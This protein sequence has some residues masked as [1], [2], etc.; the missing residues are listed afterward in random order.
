MSQTTPNSKR[1]RRGVEDDN[2][3]IE[4]A[5]DHS[6]QHSGYLVDREVL[7]NPKLPIEKR[8]KINKARNF[9]GEPEHP[10]YMSE[11][12]EVE[13][14]KYIDQMSD[15]SGFSTGPDYE[16][17]LENAGQQQQGLFMDNSGAEN[18]E[19]S[20]GLTQG[21]DFYSSFKSTPTSGGDIVQDAG[22][23]ASLDYSGGSGGFHAHSMK[24]S[25]NEE[26]L[27][28]SQSDQG[29]YGSGGTG[30]RYSRF[31]Q[32]NSNGPSSH[33]SFGGQSFDQKNSQSSQDSSNEA[34]QNGPPAMQHFMPGEDMNWQS[35]RQGGS[36]RNG[37]PTEYSYSETDGNA[38]IHNRPSPKLTFGGQSF[39]EKPSHTSSQANIHTAQGGS[40]TVNQQTQD[41]PTLQMSTLQSQAMQAKENKKTP[42]YPTGQSTGSIPNNINLNI[43]DTPQSPK[44][45]M[46]PA[47]NPSVK[48][49]S[50]P[51][52]SQIPV[53]MQ[54][55]LLP[56]VPGIS[57]TPI[58]IQLP[59]SPYDPG[60]D[61]EVVLDC[62]TCVKSDPC[63]TICNKSKGD[64]DE[65][66]DN[67]CA[68]S[69]LSVPSLCPP[70]PTI[71][72]TNCQVMATEFD[73]F[74]EMYYILEVGLRELFKPE[75][76]Q[77]GSPAFERIRKLCQSFVLRVYHDHPYYH[78]TRVKS[79][80]NS[81]DYSI[82]SM[83]IRFTQSS[84]KNIA[85]LYKAFMCKC[86]CDYFYL[87]L[88]FKLVA[89]NVTD[90]YEFCP[91]ECFQTSTSECGASSQCH[92]CCANNYPPSFLVQKV[93]N[94]IG[95]Q[96]FHLFHRLFRFHSCLQ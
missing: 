78:E 88:F 72:T 85:P 90:I 61:I 10:E 77:T 58:Q 54:P 96:R 3:H 93:P 39:D 31:G 75:M 46:L 34:M 19:E 91:K 80:K 8:D 71:D 32:T 69:V 45:V 28:S 41:K 65:I 40:P 11:G 81:K 60:P 5:S 84:L 94:M 73:V 37:K 53:I 76:A 12:G 70:C 16:I 56:A 57:P 68:N 48:P 43:Q 15:L 35:I 18:M 26:E 14:G 36:G 7:K 52:D 82:V 30:S 55:Q 22:G 1:N 17:D 66:V 6:G 33:K 21:Q 13:E 59:P 92:G 47:T 2:T 23:R 27:Y 9:H 24:P 67:C 83:L 29:G 51:L 62:T 63:W 87:D 49:P 44:P 50:Q 4:A 25:F 38:R 86:G 89:A 42:L 20:R 79:I 64:S 74:N 95:K